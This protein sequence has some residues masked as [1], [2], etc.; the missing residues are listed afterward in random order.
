MD[1]WQNPLCLGSDGK[2]VG[3]RSKQDDFELDSFINCSGTN[4]TNKQ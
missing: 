2:D 3:F 1:R 4:A